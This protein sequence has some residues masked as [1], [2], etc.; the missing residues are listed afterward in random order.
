[1][2]AIVDRTRRLE[3]IVIIPQAAAAESVSGASVGKRAQFD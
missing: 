2:V 1:M 3:T